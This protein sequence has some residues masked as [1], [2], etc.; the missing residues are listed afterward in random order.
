EVSTG[1]GAEPEP[2]ESDELTIQHELGETPIKKNPKSVVVFDYG[3]LD[4]LDKLGIEGVAGVAKD[5]LP[6]YLSKYEDDQ[7]ENIGSLKEPDF[8]KIDAMGPDLIL[9]SGRQSDLYDQLAEIA[10]TIYLGV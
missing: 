3:V 5:S 10:P 1:S 6:P 2:Q 7:Y 4:S 9:I 8:E